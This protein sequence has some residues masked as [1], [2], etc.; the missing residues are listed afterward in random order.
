[1]LPSDSSALQVVTLDLCA[2]RHAGLAPAGSRPTSSKPFRAPRTHA[3][4]RGAMAPLHS[5]A[6]MAPMRRVEPDAC[7]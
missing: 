1:M 4:R 2:A 6:S 7:A 5:G 3:V